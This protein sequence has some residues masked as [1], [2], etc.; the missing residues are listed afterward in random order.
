MASGMAGKVRRCAESD[1]FDL[2]GYSRDKCNDLAKAAFSDPFELKEMIKIT[3]VVGAGKAGRQKYG[4]ALERDWMSA[5]DSI[6]FNKDNS[7]CTELS[8]GGKYKYQH[9]TGKNL[10]FVHVFPN[11]VVPEEEEEVDEDGEPVQ[12][13]TR[14]PADVLAEVEIDDFRRMVAARV[15]SYSSKKCLLDA[16]KERVSKLDECEQKMIAREAIPPEL[17]TLYDT[18]DAT[19]LKEKMKI[20]AVEL[21]E[22]IDNGELTSEEKS[23]V[24]EQLAGKLEALQEQ[25][26]KAEAEGKAK[27][28]TKL[29]EA[30]EKLKATKATVADNSPAPIAPLTYGEEIQR[31]HK[32]IKGL[33]KLEKESAGKYTLDQLKALG[34]KPEMEEAMVVLQTRSKMWFESDDCFKVRLRH[35]LAQAPAPKKKAAGGGYPAG[36]GSSSGGWATVKR[37]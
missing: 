8:A 1:E 12:Q 34:E 18:L 4:D 7:A 10:I 32:R 26:T 9:D 31:L 16:L 19:G 33:D 20:M 24:L 35:C 17:Q 37:K 14:D 28:V 6:G 27:T 29:E 5:L 3:F 23:A 30:K 11:V 36:G 25:L 15:V 21:Q 13:G 2:G 22:S